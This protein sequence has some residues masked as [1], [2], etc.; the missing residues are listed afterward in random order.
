MEFIARILHVEAMN[1]G[2]VNTSDMDACAGRPVDAN[3]TNKQPEQSLELIMLY[4]KFKRPIH[5]YVYR[6]LGSQED[7]DDLTQEVFMRA[8]VSWDDLSDRDH[9]SPWLYRI[10]TNMCVDLLRRRKRI[11]WWPLTRRSPDLMQE[12]SSEEEVAMHSMALSPGEHVLLY[13]CSA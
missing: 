6:L 13:A 9:L 2:N 1:S 12:R 7:A 10:A 11:S 4:E 5:A 8:F 3:S